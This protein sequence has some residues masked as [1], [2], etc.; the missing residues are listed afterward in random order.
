MRELNSIFVHCSF[1]P[2]SMD[3][4]VIEIRKWHTDPKPP[5]GT[6]PVPGVHGN[7]WSDIG[8]HFVIRRDGT[9]EP[10]RDPAIAGAHAYGHN[11]DSLGF[12]LVGGMD[13]E[14]NPV[15]N[16]TFA[17][18]RALKA[19]GV[20]MADAF[21]IPYANIKGHNEVSTKPCPCFDVPGLFSAL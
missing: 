13:E 20:A 10:G 15:C 1:T 7:G 12:V 18:Y 17:Q 16:F 8:Y 19:L 21:D 14:G 5:A 4:G 3:I 11:K 2:A 6:K 9:T